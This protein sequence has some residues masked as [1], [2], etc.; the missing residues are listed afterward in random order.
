[1]GRPRPFTPQAGP[2]GGRPRAS[3]AGP[4]VR[5]CGAARLSKI[6]KVLGGFALC[7]AERLRLSGRNPQS[8]FLFRRGKAKPSRGLKWKTGYKK[9]AATERRSLSAQRRGGAADCMP[10]CESQFAQ[11]WRRRRLRYLLAAVGGEPRASQSV[12]RKSALNLSP[13]N[14]FKILLDRKSPIRYKRY[15]YTGPV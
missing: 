7:C 10:S 4:Y 1:M 11:A 13:T 8:I 2:H 14:F 6:A 5:G 12:A 15:I 3:A 9:G